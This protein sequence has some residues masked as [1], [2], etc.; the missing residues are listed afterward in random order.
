DLNV[1]GQHRVAVHKPATEGDAVC[2]VIKFL[3][4][5]LIKRLQL[6]MFQ[7]FR[8]ERCH[9]V[10]DETEVDVDVGD[11]HDVVPVNDGDSLIIK[12]SPY[13]IVQHFDDRD[14]LRHH[15][16]QIMHR[17]FFKRFCQ[18]GVVCVSAGSAY[19][20]DG[21]VHVQSSADEQTNQLRD[22]H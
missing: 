20:V 15:F 1:T 6:R 22:H 4:I 9:T 3:R 19:H 11:V 7:H 12:T 2:H 8:V 16:F 21:V 10:D 14:Q 17:P 18:N 13:L 5:N